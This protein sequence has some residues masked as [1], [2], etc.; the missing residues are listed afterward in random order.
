MVTPFHSHCSPNISILLYC[1]V[2]SH[3]AGLTDEQAP[4]ILIL[5]ERLCQAS[6]KK[7]QPIYINSYTVH[8]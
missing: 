5:L 2:L 1:S 8:R 3:N 7:G 4:C 6:A